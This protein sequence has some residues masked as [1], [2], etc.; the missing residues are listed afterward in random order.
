M[1]VL[2]KGASSVSWFTLHVSVMPLS[3]LMTARLYS[4]VTAYLLSATAVTVVVSAMSS[5][6][7]PSSSH[8]TLM[9]AGRN[10]D[11]K[12]V[13]RVVGE[14]SSK[15]GFV[16]VIDGAEGRTTNTSSI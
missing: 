1:A 9:V 8:V 13:A 3:T 16:T 7:P 15:S 11:A 12:H 14:A 4:D 10:P 2:N 6:E 5:V